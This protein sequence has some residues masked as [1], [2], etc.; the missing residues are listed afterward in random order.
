[1]AAPTAA[2]TARASTHRVALTD[3]VQVKTEVAADCKPWLGKR[4]VLR[5]ELLIHRLSECNAL[6]HKKRWSFQTVES[7]RASERLLAQLCTHADC[8]C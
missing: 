1:M 3:Q 8:T 4:A 6:L 7:Q 5:E 2:D